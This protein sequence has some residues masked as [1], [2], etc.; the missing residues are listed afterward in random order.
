MGSIS[1]RESVWLRPTS[2]LTILPKAL[3]RLSHCKNKDEIS[4]LNVEVRN[5]TSARHESGIQTHTEK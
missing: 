3:G 2:K 4:D 1:S 5:K